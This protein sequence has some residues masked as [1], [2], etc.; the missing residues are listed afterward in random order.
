MT[1][2]ALEWL[3]GNRRA[4]DLDGWVLRGGVALFFVLM[5]AE[6][7]ANG[8]GSP[9]VVMFEQIGLGQWFRYF[10]G[11]VEVVGALL[12]V[13]PWTCSIGAML[14][15]CAMLGAMTVHIVVR[16]SVAAS[17][18][19]AVVLLAI[20]AIAMRRSDEPPASITRHPETRR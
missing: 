20:I 5:G 2:R 7:F 17:L 12:Y 10:T 1:S 3:V 6:K 9:W 13:M 19:P 18:Y 11:V 8:R 15:S 16:H 14:L 4:S